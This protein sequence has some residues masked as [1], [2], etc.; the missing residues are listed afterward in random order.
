MKN[1][2]EGDILPLIVTPTE[3]VTEEVT[4]IWNGI[5]RYLILSGEKQGLNPDLFDEEEKTKI[6]SGTKAGTN[7][8]FNCIIAFETK[9]TNVTLEVSQTN[10]SEDEN[11]KFIQLVPKYC[12]SPVSESSKNLEKDETIELYLKIME[13]VENEVSINDKTFALKKEGDNNSINLNSCSKIPKDQEKGTITISCKVENEVKEGIYTL[14]LVEGK[15]IDN[16][17]PMVSGFITFTNQNEKAET[18][19]QAPTQA[20]T[21][22]PTQE[23]TQAPT[24]E[25]TQ[26][27]TQASTQALTQAPEQVSEDTANSG[28]NIDGYFI[29]KLYLL[30]IISF[31]LF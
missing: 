2:E 26:N 24:Q 14:E 13:K 22:T 11:N 29:L 10:W 20:P 7:I 18:P 6:P 28:A 4:I 15:T 5:I 1:F 12:I 23:S 27:S 9:D 16:I 19:T 25:S 30:R 8:N 17:K 3:D 31:L 21:Q